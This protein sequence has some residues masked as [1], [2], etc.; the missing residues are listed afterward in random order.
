MGIVGTDFASIG[1]TGG[2]TGSC[3]P[4][5][6]ADG[7]DG[8]QHTTRRPEVE[9]W[10]VPSRTARRPELAP[11]RLSRR[12][13]ARVRRDTGAVVRAAAGQPR[14]ELRLK[15]AALCE[16]EEDRPGLDVL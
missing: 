2:I 8:R 5:I 13:S 4:L 10:A 15:L 11:T 9:K 1:L 12:D 16:P 7:A 3:M 6:M 14:R